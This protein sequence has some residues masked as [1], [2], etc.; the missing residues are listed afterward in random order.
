[1]A[2]IERR[3]F[4]KSLIAGGATVSERKERRNH[5]AHHEGTRLYHGP[6]LIPAYIAGIIAEHPALKRTTN[7]RHLVSRYADATHTWLFRCQIPAH[8]LMV[9]EIVRTPE[10]KIRVHCWSA[11]D[12]ERYTRGDEP[13]VIIAAKEAKTSQPCMPDG[14]D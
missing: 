5:R 13:G 8:C 14:W 6:M 9:G 1:M 10:G 7:G 12:P 2:N 3:D 4:F 11:A